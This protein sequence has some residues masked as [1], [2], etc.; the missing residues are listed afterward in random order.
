MLL[1]YFAI[2]YFF[3][4][5]LIALPF[6]TVSKN[7]RDWNYF[8][9]FFFILA[10]PFLF[11]NLEL[12]FNKTKGCFTYV[13]GYLPFGFFFGILAFVLLYFINAKITK[14]NISKTQQ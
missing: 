14:S 7:I 9:L 12:K 5:L 2:S 1:P 8:I 3:A 6:K 13:V 11:I 4:P 10:N